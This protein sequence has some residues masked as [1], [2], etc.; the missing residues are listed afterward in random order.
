MNERFWVG[1]LEWYDRPLNQMIA[2][3]VEE[4]DDKFRYI[5]LRNHG[6][7]F[8]NTSSAAEFASLSKTV[9]MFADQ[10]DQKGNAITKIWEL[11]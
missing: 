7:M 3:T 11:K 8:F 9:G 4:Y 2:Q 6:T 1:K 10:I 5:D